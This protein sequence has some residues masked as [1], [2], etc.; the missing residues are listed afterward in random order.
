[1]SGSLKRRSFL[2]MM[3][4]GGVGS[5]LAACDLPSTVTLEEGKED[6]VSYF[7]PEE[8]V[9]PGVGVWYSSTCMQCDNGCGIQA[10]VRE[11][12]VLKIEGNPNSP[13]NKGTMCQMG[14]A[15]IQAQY[16]P[17][18]ITEPMLREG[19]SLKKVSWEKAIGALKVNTASAGNKVA[20]FTGTI[21]G[22]QSA[23]IQNYLDASG[24]SKNHYVHE[25]VNNAVWQ[26]VSKDML[27]DSN[28]KI[29]IK[30]ARLV[31]SFGADFLATWGS[32]LNNAGQ[33]A[34]FRSASSGQG[35]GSLIQIESKMSLT[36]GN[37]DLW[38]AIKPGSEGAMAL[39]VANYILGKN[40][41]AG[42]SLRE[43]QR[44]YISSFGLDKT[45]TIAG[46]TSGH[47]QRVAEALL[48]RSPS[49]VLA[50]APAE[51]QESGYD[52]VAAVMLLNVILG[53]V[54]KTIVPSASDAFPQL[55]AKTGST[56]D[57]IEFTKAV[58]AKSFDLVFFSGTNPVYSAP[59]MLGFEKAISNVGFKVAIS[60]FP[61]ETTMAADLVLPASSYLED[62]GTHV[63]AVQGEQTVVSIQQPMM[64]NLYESTRG[65]GDI[66]L[67]LL[68]DKQPDQ[69][70]AYKDYYAYLQNAVKT[71]QGSSAVT[72]SDSA[73]NFWN[74]SLQTGVIAYKAASKDFKQNNVSIKV[75]EGSADNAYPYT[76]IPSP[77]M[78]L[79][80]GRHANLPWL[81]ESPDQIAKVVWDS[82]AEMHPNTANKLGVKHG[83]MLKIESDAGSINAKAYVFKGI[84]PDAIAVPLGQGHTEHGRYAK[85]L[86]TNP[87]K[88][89]SAKA[90]KKT[91]ELAMYATR[92]KVSGAI[93]GDKLVRMGGNDAQVGR[94]FVRTIPV[95]VLKRTEGA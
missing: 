77:R 46:T 39:G 4:L 38:V 68:K 93:D 3:G 59:D 55:A 75:S 28:P 27:G 32:T 71:M 52:S 87:L 58:N 42:S 8:Y 7:M 82:W 86:G 64:E 20:W 25:V 92:V 66:L 34:Q 73:K 67:T 6:V 72:N 85:N 26:A 61:D 45:A 43:E 94:R 24:A 37:A 60:M 49:V 44:S 50:G 57:L 15:G 84:H 13:V 51:G 48:N 23:L 9:I 95:D 53:N 41:A 65:L 54:G 79:Y 83:Q 88:I 76:L 56:R 90:D 22:H 10:R 78:G 81:Q 5:T 69:Y 35:R 36:G 30:D 2:K 40:P 16:N 14:Q 63:P 18:R 12:R 31:V 19:G 11:G 17:D 33:Y 89:V 1:M 47:V 74:T 91:G 29:N 70:G 21:S 62:W 80:D